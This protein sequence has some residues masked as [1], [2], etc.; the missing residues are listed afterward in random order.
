MYADTCIHCV[1]F[2]IILQTDGS[3]S[4]QPLRSQLV[5][6]TWPDLISPLLKPCFFSLLHQ[7]WY[8]FNLL[9]TQHILPVCKQ[10]ERHSWSLTPYFIT[11]ISKKKLLDLINYHHKVSYTFN[12]TTIINGELIILI[13]QTLARYSYTF[14]ALIFGF[15]PYENVVAGPKQVNILTFLLWNVTSS[16]YRLADYEV[17]KMHRASHLPSC[18]VII[19]GM[20]WYFSKN[21]K[22][23]VRTTKYS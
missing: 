19:S 14:L 2:L 17:W 21:N 9:L 7:S 23:T 4:T 20:G 6:P 22:F 12:T 10:T 1:Y 18:T 3:T 16:L 13:A 15:S 11:T 5:S 8:C